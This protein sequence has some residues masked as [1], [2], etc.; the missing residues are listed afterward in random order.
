MKKSC[1]RV[2]RC[3]SIVPD[4]F[5]LRG[6]HNLCHGM[7]QM[8]VPRPCPAAGLDVSRFAL[9]VEVLGCDLVKHTKQDQHCQDDSHKLRDKMSLLPSLLMEVIS[10]IS[11]YDQVCK[12]SSSVRT[13]CNGDE[14]LT[15]ID[16]DLFDDEPFGVAS[17][18]HRYCH[19]EHAYCE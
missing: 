6:R 18:H 5:T 12:G 9:E 17:N 10:H 7:S 16:S 2:S 14:V 11:E 13:G 8:W 1:R 4:G 19:E 15:I 3:C